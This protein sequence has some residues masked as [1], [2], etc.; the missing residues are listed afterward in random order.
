MN[1]CRSELGDL[2]SG[3]EVLSEGDRRELPPVGGRCGGGGGR[4]LLPRQHD[5][6]HQ[7]QAERE[8]S[9]RRPRRGED[10]L[11]RR[12]ERRRRR[13]EREKE[14]KALKRSIRRPRRE[15]QRA[16]YTQSRKKMQKSD[17]TYV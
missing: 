9:H 12:H 16:Q 4:R 6:E 3:D 5:L 13:R 2:Q 17:Y 11:S 1:P 7:R 14:A 10:L 8:G 15:L